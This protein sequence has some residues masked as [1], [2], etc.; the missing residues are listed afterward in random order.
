M[1]RRDTTLD[2]VKGILILFLLYYHTIDISRLWLG[3]SS[4]DLLFFETGQFLVK[5][6]WM[7]TFFIVTGICSNFDIDFKSYVYKTLQGIF[8]PTLLF[9]IL[10]AIIKSI[11]TQNI[12]PI[13]GLFSLHSISTCFDLWFIAA[14][15]ISKTLYYFIHILN[16]KWLFFS[17]LAIFTVLGA[18]SYENGMS[19]YSYHQ[20]AL[21]MLPMLYIGQLI[22]KYEVLEYKKII[23]LLSA[24]YPILLIL[25][26]HYDIH[27]PRNVIEELFEW[28]EL[29]LYCIICILGFC[30]FY[31]TALIF[32]RFTLLSYIGKQTL[33]I[34]CMNF[35]FIEYTLRGLY[36][37][38]IPDSFFNS[39]VIIAV[40]ML[41]SGIMGIL[42]S[43]L[44]NKIRRLGVSG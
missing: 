22:R 33:A 15:L 29:P 12:S 5:S 28:I 21:L 34:Y 4:E 35:V 37:F 40:S 16:R 43:E 30:F 26:N 13:Y 25:L 9:C 20:H 39:M 19:N 2:C 7:S 18:I 32:K 11:C 14:L 42:V 8:L 6:S 36:K 1:K 41:V 31:T 17:A 10:A 23:L 24:L 44:Y 3:V 38:V 27:I